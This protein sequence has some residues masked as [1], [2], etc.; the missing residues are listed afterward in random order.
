[1]GLC[2][3]ANLRKTVFYLRRNGLKKTWSALRE[4]LEQRKAE[5][6]TFVPVT[7]E[8]LEKQR[9][10]FAP[11]GQGAEDTGLGE[12]TI[13]TGVEKLPCFSILVPA[14]RTKEIFLRELL[15]CLRNQSYPHWELLL[16]DA[17]QDDSV[18][19]SLKEWLQEK[20][21]EQRIRYIHLEE[22]GGISQNTNAALKYVTGDYVGLLDHDDV[23]TPDALY[24]MACGIITA[25]EKG[26]ELQMLYSDEDKCNG[27]RTQYYE[28]N[29]KEDFNLD[30]LLC[31]NYICHFLVLKSELVQE[32]GFRKEYD[33]AQDY[34]L[35]LRA[36]GR[37]LPE[38]SK[39]LHIPKVLYHWRCHGDSTA[40]NPQSKLW[41][42]E[43]GR[44][45]LQ[46]FADSRN[47]HAKAGHTEHMGF[48]SLDYEGDLW[49][50]RPDLGAVGGKVLQKSR[51]AGGRY[52]WEGRLY[53]ENLPEH[54]SGYLHRAVLSQDALAVDIRCIMIRPELRE[55]FAQIVGVPYQTRV[56]KSK[57]GKEWEIF[58]AS[59]LPDGTDYIA[60]SLDWAKAVRQ[61]DLN[62]MWNPDVIIRL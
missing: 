23:L 21:E 57:E 42:Y 8:E 36:A 2:N 3:M 11:A 22:N 16:A 19:Q 52:D 34:D 54:Y 45:A 49:S 26:V 24:E 62:L 44:K 10:A 14:Y 1:M 28:P 38:C 13:G 29:Y 37:I 39:I 56:V 46:D 20:G 59:Q 30:L 7:E 50:S 55:L 41:A 9:A 61:Q 5:A 17:T 31:N 58:D 51:I 53:Y 25:R 27:D 12:H 4:R 60:L 48:Y 32:L 47:Y 33:G 43:A 35:V 18:E 15:D 40:E 6:Y